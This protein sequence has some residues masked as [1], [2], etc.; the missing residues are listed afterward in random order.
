[1]PPGGGD[2][3][4]EYMYSVWIQNTMEYSVRSRADSF[5]PG[6]MVM[7]LAMVRLLLDGSHPN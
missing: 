3:T 5:E 1:M 7:L 2:N 4:P 6:S